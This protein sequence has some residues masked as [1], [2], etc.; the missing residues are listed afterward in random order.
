[1][2]ADQEEGALGVADASDMRWT[3]AAAKGRPDRHPPHASAHPDPLLCAFD[4][5]PLLRSPT[6]VSPSVTVG[7]LLLP[8]LA[9]ASALPSLMSSAAAAGE[10][11]R[12]VRGQPPPITLRQRTTRLR[13]R[14]WLCSACVASRCEVAH[15]HACCPP[16]CVARCVCFRCPCLSVRS[17]GAGRLRRSA[18]HQSAAQVSVTQRTQLGASKPISHL[19]PPGLCSSPSVCVPSPRRPLAAALAATTAAGTWPSTC[20]RRPSLTSSASTA[21]HT[22]RSWRGTMRLRQAA[23]P[24]GSERRSTTPRPQRPA[25]RRLSRTSLQTRP[26]RLQRRQPPQSA[27]ALSPKLPLLLPLLRLPLALRLCRPISRASRRSCR[28]HRRVRT[29]WCCCAQ[30][31]SGRR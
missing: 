6:T 5:I 19:S 17:A 27:R 2:V 10:W 7:R 1:M 29:C 9:V 13:S 11:L 16:L 31:M 26:P 8:L 24:A 28:H 18:A 20:R 23:L 25:R 14:E 22:A 12:P 15:L 4:L 3:A 21:L 30:R